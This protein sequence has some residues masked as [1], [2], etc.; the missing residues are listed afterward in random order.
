MSLKQALGCTMLLAAC[1]STPSAQTAGITCSI[2]QNCA[3][4]FCDDG[5]CA[6]PKGPF[7]ASC[8][9]APRTPDGI[10]D[11][12]LHACGAYVCIEGRCRSCTS[13]TQCREELG[14]P[15]CTAIADTPGRRCGR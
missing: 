9:P 3:S 11:G 2:D 14:A 4:G 12:K 6:L 8:T 1:T 10:S 5:R 13:D 15:R 7:G